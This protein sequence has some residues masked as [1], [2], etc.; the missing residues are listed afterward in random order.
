VLFQLSASSVVQEAAT[1]RE[2]S[3]IT[4][5]SMSCGPTGSASHLTGLLY[6]PI[7]AKR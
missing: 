5:A 2:P 3:A 1:R 4:P 7:G 6:V